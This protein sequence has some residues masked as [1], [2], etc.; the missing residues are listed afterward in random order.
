[1]STPEGHEPPK[2]HSLLGQ[3]GFAFAL[4]GTVMLFVPDSAAMGRNV[5]LLALA[6]SVIA[7]LVPGRKR[8][9]PLIGMVLSAAVT[10]ATTLGWIPV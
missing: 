9:L 1:M 6:I 10:V 5:V 2:Q 3:V 4:I 7:A 8:I